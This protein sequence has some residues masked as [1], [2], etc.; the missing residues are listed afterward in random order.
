MKIALIS[1]VHSN[2]E[3]LT[4]VFKNIDSLNINKIICMGDLIGYGPDPAEVISAIINRKIICVKGNHDAASYDKYALEMMNCNASKVLKKHIKMLSEEQ[5]DFLYEL[6]VFIKQNNLLFVHGAPPDSFYEYTN[7]Y[8]EEKLY[9]L[10]SSGNE[11]G[12][13]V[14]HTHIPFLCE[15]LIYPRKLKLTELQPDIVYSIN[16]RTDKFL[17][18]C[19][20]VGM[21][22][23]KYDKNAK[24]MI[25][26]EENKTVEM[27][28]VFYDSEV[29]IKK[30]K[31]LGFP[32]ELIS[33][34]EK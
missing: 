5:I 14:G 13:V 31:D 2:L 27:K 15:Y 11:K 3:A 4:A 12:Y 29:T 24:Y 33:F 9:F 16:K 30:M 18:S 19:G 21:P 32:A 1:D 22:R 25:Y 7:Y 17:I 20:S 10:L 28:T 34:L 6:P 8:D 26:N 23:D